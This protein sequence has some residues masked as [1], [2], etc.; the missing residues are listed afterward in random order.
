[1][2][3]LIEQK[4]QVAPKPRPM[5]WHSMSVTFQKKVQYTKAHDDWTIFQNGLT[6]SRQLEFWIAMLE[7]TEYRIEQ[8]ED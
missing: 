4:H 1:M 5:I 2:A 6:R 3:K 7:F 8:R